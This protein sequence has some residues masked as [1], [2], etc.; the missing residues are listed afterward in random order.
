MKSNHKKPKMVEK[1]SKLP[2]SFIVYVFGIGMMYHLRVVYPYYCN[3]YIH[4]VM[5]LGTQGQTETL[6]RCYAEIMMGLHQ[7]R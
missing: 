4:N 7:P 3:H 2:F 6:T 1:F 5:A